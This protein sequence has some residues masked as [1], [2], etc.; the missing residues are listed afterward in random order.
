MFD[1]STSLGLFRESGI[2]DEEKDL[3]MEEA[4]GMDSVSLEEKSRMKSL[5]KMKKETMRKKCT[6]KM[7]KWKK[8]DSKKKGCGR[9]E[10]ERQNWC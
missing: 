7:M 6:M 3:V 8:R 2:P 1:Q 9:G 4:V 10:E 5:M